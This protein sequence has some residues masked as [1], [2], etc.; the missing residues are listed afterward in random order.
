MS[1]GGDPCNRGQFMGHKPSTRV[2]AHPGGNSSFSLGWGEPE[3]QKKA[4]PMQPA[5]QP[6]MQ[7]GKENAAP[8][9]P[10]NVVPQQ[11][12][13]PQK[14]QAPQGNN[15]ISSNAWASNASQNCGNVI[16]DRPSTRIHA[17]PGGKSSITF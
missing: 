4:A 10:A 17:P 5:M 2:H 3:P 11:Q 16:S 15:R 6:V 9:M 13:E 1:V 8:A 14:G 12:P 7:H